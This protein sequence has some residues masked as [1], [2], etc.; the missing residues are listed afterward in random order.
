M[1]R[2]AELEILEAA[3]KW[4]E[5]RA[6]NIGPMSDVEQRLYNAAIMLRSVRRATGSLRIPTGKKVE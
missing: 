3:M 6:R 1:V 5:R 2:R 4:A